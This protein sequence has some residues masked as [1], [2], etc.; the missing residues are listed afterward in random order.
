MV[1]EDD[2]L[3]QTIVEE[4]L[5]EGGFHP[6]VA[7]SGEEALTLLQNEESKYL[8]LITDV[9][10]SGALIGW[11]VARRARELNPHIP[12]V[13]MTGAAADDWS[14]PCVP[15]SMLLQKPFAPAQVVT[16]ISQLLNQVPPTH[17]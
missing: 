17:E 2:P 11:D 16:A 10:L 15:H 12:V 8:A 6:E 7:S 14:S 13:Y 1:V 4:A 5:A 3:I 9:N